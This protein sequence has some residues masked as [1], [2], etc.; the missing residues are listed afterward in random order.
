MSPLKSKQPVSKVM[1]TAV[2]TVTTNTGISSAVRLLEGAAL[3]HLIVLDDDRKTLAGVTCLKD[4]KRAR[5]KEYIH[6]CMKSPVFCVS[7]TEIVQDA[8]K[9]MDQHNVSFLAVVVEG[10]LVG[11]ITREML[12]ETEK[13]GETIKISDES[14]VFS[15]AN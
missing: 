4:L 9:I 2:L 5:G 6:E 15:R 8:L 12:T 1:R 10:R 7:G 3:R 11:A 13:V 14:V